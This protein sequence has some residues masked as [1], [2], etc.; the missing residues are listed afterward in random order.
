MTLTPKQVAAYDD[1]S[2]A[3]DKAAII[4]EAIDVSRLNAEER[5]HLAEVIADARK[6]KATL[7]GQA[8]DQF[9]RERGLRE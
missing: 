1:A 7:Y 3:V 5:E 8:Y 4:L 6:L 2:R 9:L